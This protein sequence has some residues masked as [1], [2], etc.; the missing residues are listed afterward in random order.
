M[1][2]IVKKSGFTGY[3][4]VEYEGNLQSEEEGIRLTKALIE[5]YW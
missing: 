1:L 5:R 3:I 4:G 2:G